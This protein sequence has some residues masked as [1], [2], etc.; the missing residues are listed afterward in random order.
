MNRLALSFLIALLLLGG[1][2]T[3][4]AA[5]DLSPLFNPQTMMPIDQI[6]AGMRGTIRSVYQ[7][8]TITENH[9]EILG[10]L[11]KFNSGEDVIMAKLLDGPSVDEKIGPIA[12][13]SGSPVYINGKLIGAL[14]FAPDFLKEPIFLITAINSMLQA[15][16]RE[17][18]AAQQPKETRVASAAL[19]PGRG[20]TVDGH[21]ITRARVSLD[22]TGPFADDHTLNVRPCEPLLLC[23][24]FSDRA[25]QGLS[26]VF[27][28]YGVTPLAGPG[29]RRDPVDVK[30][31]PGSS[32]GVQLL[33]GDFDVSGIGTVTYMQNQR[34]LAFGH[35]MLKLGG[36]DFPLTT[37]WI[38]G[39]LPC[40]N[41]AM[42]SG[43]IMKRVGALTQDTPFAIG[44]N[45]GGQFPSVPVE[46]VITDADSGLKHSYSFSTVDHD[47]LTP[48]L[49]L[50]GISSALD[51][52]YSPGACGMMETR[53]TLEGSRGA[54]VP[55]SNTAYF[56]SQ[57]LND[58]AQDI[59]GAAALFRYNLWAPQSL[60]HVRLEATLLNRDRTAMV[61]RI[62]SEQAVGKAGQP[63]PLHVVVR[64]WGAPPVD[65]RVVLNL[66]ADLPATNLEIGAAGGSLADALR[67]HL[68]LLTPDYDS[69]EGMLGEFARQEKNDE[70][71]VA[72]AGTAQG[73]SVGGTRLPQVPQS[74]GA[75]FSATIQQYVAEGFQEFSVKQKLPWVLFGGALVTVPVE[76]RLGQRP[77]PP[78]SGE[79]KK[80]PS[81]HGGPPSPP[82][83][84]GA[85]GDHPSPSP[86]PSGSVWPTL[87]APLT[88]FV[89]PDYP[90]HSLAWAARGL[91]PDIAALVLA[92][93]QDDEP[94]GGDS[95]PP[96]PSPKTRVGAPEGPSGPAKPGSEKPKPEAKKEAP[97]KESEA[98]KTEEGVGLVLRQPSDF[99][100][101]EAA[102]FKDG[103]TRGT[104]LASEGG[105]LL[106]APWKQTASVPDHTLLASACAPDGTLYFSSVGGRVFRL[107]NGQPRLFCDTKEFS[108]TAL[109]VRADG[110]V[111]AGCS[112]SGKLLAISPQGQA[113][114]LCQT[115]ALYIW[116]LT[117]APDGTLYA[118]TGPHGVLYQLRPGGACTAFTT[119]PA[120]H[121]LA[122]AWR[123]PQLIAGTCQTGGVFVVAPD[124]SSH[125]VFGSTD[126]DITAVAV[127]QAGNLYAGTTPGGDVVQIA[128]DGQVRTVF[129]DSDS[130]VYSLLATADGVYV[131]TAPNGQIFLIRDADHTS[132][133]L[134]DSPA[135]FVTQMVAGP[136]GRAYALG[137]GPG[138]VLGCSLTAPRE[139]TYASTSLDATL[140]STWGKLT[141]LADA[142]PG[143]VTLR[144][145]SGNSE[146]PEDGSWSAWSAPVANGALLDLPAARYLQYHLRLQGPADKPVLVRGLDLSY[147]P[148]NQPPKLELKS[149]SS[150]DSVHGKV[151]LAWDASDPDGDALQTTLYLRPPGGKWEKLAGPLTD[152]DYEWDTTDLKP[153][154]YSLRLVV[155]DVR[156]N[157]VGWLEATADLQDVLVDNGVPTLV[158]RLA[159]G[160][161]Q[162]A[163]IEGS[164]MEEVSGVVS[165]AWKNAEDDKGSD[166][167]WT[168]A[169]LSTPPFGAP[170]VSFTIP[171]RQ[172]PADV[173]IITIRAIDDAGAYTDLN[174]DLT[175]GEATPVPEEAA[176]S[177]GV[178]PTSNEKPAAPAKP[179]KPAGTEPAAG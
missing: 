52:A 94:P 57:P 41:R 161:K 24:G 76:D 174:L 5:A 155:S 74:V 117:L 125:L 126:D 135:A 48:M 124:G 142:P 71:L 141:W 59:L 147:L 143:A 11:Q 106:V 65:E 50:M 152:T 34:V 109:A 35:Q 131:G 13:M 10:V 12:G 103:V 127:D 53:L 179:A 129:S 119:L 159:A 46:V 56:E 49:V 93:P 30:L 136:D 33:W 96:G 73:M 16:D 70:L 42:K 38:Q 15:W 167:V 116:A 83:A 153:G 166:A 128:P 69:L 114:L 90:P 77:A 151:K 51:G 72:A 99:A 4:F 164:A 146:D 37:A 44:G 173:K 111:L 60:K 160:E 19:A 154:R 22:A 107:T 63:L 1:A 2:A 88:T 100:Q 115:P 177:E 68:G 61:E 79:E 14:A 149:P 91:R 113:S 176:P 168:A 86:A 58:L 156:S 175:T 137:N 118:G 170:L 95:G 23:S 120:H 26:Q 98:K 165:V 7:G 97:A 29:P 67:D 171:R 162:T 133:V 172:I 163:R 18:G 148:A 66:P 134:L 145:R 158:A 25:L 75:L 47:A 81:S 80:K 178:A 62:Y 132:S 40:M 101:V 78:S 82:S 122:L 55:R 3:A 28:R 144:C 17:D 87:P 54:S 138:G 31:E 39:I 32:V 21:R 9:V 6:E 36:V 89:L 169:I 20:A 157:P 139:G 92:R 102:D 27:A 110:T 105:V 43:S 123:G 84:G 45:V 85:P 108:V 150:G 64:P 104:G 8:A 140:L 130:A 121:L 112:P